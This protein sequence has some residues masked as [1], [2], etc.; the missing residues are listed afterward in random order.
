MGCMQRKAVGL[1]LITLSPRPDALVL[2]GGRKRGQVL[3]ER[4]LGWVW[5]GAPPPPP[6]P[7]GSSSSTPSQGDSYRQKRGSGSWLAEAGRQ[8]RRRAVGRVE[9]AARVCGPAWEGSGHGAVAPVHPLAHPVPG[10]TAQP[11]CDLGWSPSVRAGAGPPGWRPSVP[12]AQQPAAPCHQ[13]AGSQPASPD[14][15]GEMGHR[16][17]CR[18]VGGGRRPR[19]VPRRLMHCTSGPAVKRGGWP[20]LWAW[21]GGYVGVLTLKIQGWPP[22]G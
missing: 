1:R 13:P 16:Q 10:A 20:Q 3:L 15:P 4:G 12:A 9:E 21:H 19:L 17:A 8:A 2:A 14:V 5:P 11:P 22:Q 7:H 18:R 6:P